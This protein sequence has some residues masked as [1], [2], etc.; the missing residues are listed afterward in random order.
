MIQTDA[1]TNNAICT[2]NTKIEFLI[3][4]TFSMLPVMASLLSLTCRSKNSFQ[5]F[6]W[7]V[8]KYGFTTLNKG[9]FK[10]LKMVKNT[11]ALIVATMGP[12]ELLAK[13]D[14]KNPKAATVNKEKLAK[15]KAPRY[16]Q[17]T[18]CSWIN[19]T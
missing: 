16:L 4:A 3:L 2:V 9:I 18:S 19:T 5:L 11:I 12:I 1:P 15:T 14:I 7:V 6:I 17:K 10:V 13:L 8:N